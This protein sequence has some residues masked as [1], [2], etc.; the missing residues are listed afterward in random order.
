MKQAEKQAR[1]RAQNWANANGK[2]CWLHC[3]NDKSWWM[4]QKPVD[5]GEII[6]PEVKPITILVRDLKPGDFIP[7]HKLTVKDVDCFGPLAI[8]DF[9]DDTASPPMS[10]GTKVE[11][12]RHA[13]KATAGPVPAGTV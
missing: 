2:P 4:S 3:Y 5:G 11:V 9:D 1:E 13:D 6:R 10:S 7:S 8:I 12:I